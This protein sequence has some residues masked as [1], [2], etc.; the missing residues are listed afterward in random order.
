MA[1]SKEEIEKLE[2]I[3]NDKF[4]FVK[5]FFHI[6]SNRYYTRVCFSNN[7]R[8][9]RQTAAWRLE[10]KLNRKLDTRKTGG[11]ESVDHIDNNKLNDHPDNLQLLTMS[12]NS[13]KS[14]QDNDFTC[15]NAKYSKLTN[16]EVNEI[17]RLYFYERVRPLEISK[18]FNMEVH[19]IRDIL[20]GKI[21]K[22][23]SFEKP[24][25]FSKPFFSTKFS[26]K[27]ILKILNLYYNELKNV[28]EIS[29]IMNCHHD[30][31][32][33]INRKSWTHVYFKI[34]DSFKHIHSN[35]K[36]TKEDVIKI[37]LKHS[38]LNESVTNISKEYGICL[39]HIRNIINNKKWKNVQT[40]DVYHITIYGKQIFAIP[41][42]IIKIENVDYKFMG[43]LSNNIPNY[44]CLYINNDDQLVKRKLNV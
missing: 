15:E 34:P 42:Q 43:R 9:Q 44:N 38:L 7:E 10:I 31:Y 29:K 37:K 14:F 11:C 1:L 6:S 39:R 13:A 25:N 24:K 8:I 17:R 21:W 36:L 20:R 3:W 27:D 30:I 26:E 4:V 5:E 32:D 33:I 22:N 35:M 41:N 16:K 18:K 40:P 19:T 23:L 12:E 2:E 28:K